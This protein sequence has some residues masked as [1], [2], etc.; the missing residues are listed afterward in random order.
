MQP[1]I[2]SEVPVTMAELKEGIAK[3]RKRSGEP[4]FR[5]KRT[6]EYLTSF[7]TLSV[8]DAAE[9]FDKLTKLNVPRLKD[10][11]ICKIID[12]MPADVNDLKVV[13]QGYTISVSNDSLKKIIDVVS[14]YK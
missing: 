9:L 3:A 7:D 14:E 8:K 13:L 11:H 10:V 2:I 6:E 4:S 5:V 1:T 12:Q